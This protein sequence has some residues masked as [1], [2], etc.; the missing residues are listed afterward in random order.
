MKNQTNLSNIINWVTE[1]INLKIERTKNVN[2]DDREND[3]NRFFQKR[4]RR[5]SLK[6]PSLWSNHR[7]TLS[8]AFQEKTKRKS[9]GWKEDEFLFF[10]YEYQTNQHFALIRIIMIFLNWLGNVIYI[11]FEIQ[12]NT[13]FLLFHRNLC[14]R[15][16]T[17][18]IHT[19]A[20]FWRTFLK[21]YIAPFS[22]ANCFCILGSISYITRN[23][24][25]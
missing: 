8:Q 16:N 4:G 5:K 14:P 7:N 9:G 25:E 15:L 21:E 20:P 18:F 17:H 6:I 13:S 10:I 2:I 24:Q 22:N 12:K 23:A 11:G 1:F 3:S 19:F